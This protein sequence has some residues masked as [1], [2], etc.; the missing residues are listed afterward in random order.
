M[1]SRRLRRRNVFLRTCGS[2]LD[3]DAAGCGDTGVSLP[4]HRLC[5]WRLPSAAALGGT[6][7]R[8]G[9]RSCRRSTPRRSRHHGSPTDTSWPRTRRSTPTT[10]LSRAR[11]LDPV[12]LEPYWAAW[13][14]A[15]TRVGPRGRPETETHSRS[16]RAQ[17]PCC[18][19]WG[20]L[21]SG[22]GSVPM[23]QVSYAKLIC[24]TRSSPRLTKLS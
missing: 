9:R 8:D 18:T 23:R 11:R 1:R 14:L 3:L 22:T 24:S 13:E 5:G 17:S 4:R 12:S 6:P 7:R 15:A 20:S 21:S 2:R 19:N 10:D 16:N